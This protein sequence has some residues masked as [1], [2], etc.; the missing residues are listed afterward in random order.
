MTK[1][2]KNWTSF[3]NFVPKLNLS[4]N[5]Y[6]PRE[7]DFLIRVC[8]DDFFMVFCEVL[9][10]EIGQE[11]KIPWLLHQ[12][13]TCKHEPSGIYP[14]RTSPMKKKEKKRYFHCGPKM[15]VRI[16][17]VFVSFGIWGHFL[18][19]LFLSSLSFKICGFVHEPFEH[20][21]HLTYSLL[22]RKQFPRESFIYYLWCWVEDI[23]T[24]SSW[25]SYLLQIW[26]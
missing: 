22:S 9:V 15:F 18:S 20:F 14:N 26:H 24:L 7:F 1:E 23:A 21:C 25:L 11:H 13:Y 2:N 16:F 3:K 6:F 4:N 12:Y 17:A 8:R 19:F 10:S 5:I